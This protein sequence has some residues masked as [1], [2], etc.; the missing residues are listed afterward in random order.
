MINGNETKEDEKRNKE[1]TG[2]NSSKVLEL[3]IF[4]KHIHFVLQH[5]GR[6]QTFASGDSQKLGLL[7]S[8]PPPPVLQAGT[9]KTGFRV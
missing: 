5:W 4:L 6:V 3:L 1:P 7:R 2:K 8:V 9:W